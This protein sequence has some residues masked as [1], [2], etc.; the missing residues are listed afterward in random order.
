MAWD[1]K[2]HVVVLFGGASWKETLGDTWEL[3]RVA[4]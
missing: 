2:R 3:R 4:R 1:A